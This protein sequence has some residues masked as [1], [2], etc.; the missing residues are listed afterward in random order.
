MDRADLEQAPPPRTVRYSGTRASQRRLTVTPRA[1]KTGTD[2]RGAASAVDDLLFGVAPLPRPPSAVGDVTFLAVA[3]AA[4]AV[5]AAPR[6][7]RQFE[8]GLALSQRHD[9]I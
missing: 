7:D 4:V 1:G 5:A 6:P 3:A 2:A 9:R 8:C